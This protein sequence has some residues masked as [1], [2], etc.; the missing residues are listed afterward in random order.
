MLTYKYLR[1][2]SEAAL[3]AALPFARNETEIEG[4]EWLTKGKGWSL[5]VIGKL[6]DPAQPGE[7]EAETGAEITPQGWLPGF[8]A[9]MIV[10][11]TFAETI[12]N[13]IVID[14]PNTPQRKWA[15]QPS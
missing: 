15:G 14:N 5:D 2:D 6:P 8:H 9:N 12:P 13:E 11:Q 7:Y 3:I 10:K 4:G 1:A